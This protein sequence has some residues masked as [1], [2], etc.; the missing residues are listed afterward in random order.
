M[1]EGREGW[2]GESLRGNHR[3]GYNCICDQQAQTPLREAR[4]GQCLA[5]HGKSPE[6]GTAA[7]TPVLLFS[8]KHEL[9]TKGPQN[10]EIMK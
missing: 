6:P 5:S 10:H 7:H 1:A 8:D 2:Q 9:I 4:L 3:N